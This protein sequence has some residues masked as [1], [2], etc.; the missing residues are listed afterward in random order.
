MSANEIANKPIMVTQ[1]VSDAIWKI[2]VDLKKKLGHVPSKGEV[3]QIL[4][5]S[6]E[7]GQK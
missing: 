4:V 2:Q 6:Y 5:K 1:S 7:E 3:V